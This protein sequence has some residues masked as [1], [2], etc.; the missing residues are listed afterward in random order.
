MLVALLLG[1]AFVASVPA[2][3]YMDDPSVMPKPG[4]GEKSAE[5]VHTPEDCKLDEKFDEEKKKCVR[6]EPM[7][8]DPPTEI[9]KETFGNYA[10]AAF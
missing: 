10:S 7:P 5:A 4:A 2:R 8:A 9:G 6:K 1:V 3:E